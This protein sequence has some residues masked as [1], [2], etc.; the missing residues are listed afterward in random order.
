V[1]RETQAQW[2]A[3]V[4]CSGAFPLDGDTE[5]DG[6]VMSD[7]EKAQIVVRNKQQR[8]VVDDY[9]AS[10]EVDAEIV[11]VTGGIGLQ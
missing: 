3:I 6:R 4:M 8:A 1:S 5:L 7:I 9:L 10:W 2:T 11:L